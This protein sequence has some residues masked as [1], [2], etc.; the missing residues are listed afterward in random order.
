MNALRMHQVE[1]GRQQH[2]DIERKVQQLVEDYNRLVHEESWAEA[3]MVASTS[4]G[5]CAQ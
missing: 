3:R 4:Q 1:S 5:N 2:I